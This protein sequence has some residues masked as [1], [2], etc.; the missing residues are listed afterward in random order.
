M[1]RGR[2]RKAESLKALE[3]TQREDRKN[4]NVSKSTILLPKPPENL[5]TWQRMAWVDLAALINPLRI[6][7]DADIIAFRQM[8]IA[9]GIVEQARKALDDAGSLTYEIP[10]TAGGTRLVPRPEVEVMAKYQRILDMKLAQFGMTPADRERVAAAPA[11]V[12]DD[13]LDEFAVNG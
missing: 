5:N 3:G 4:Q 6:T 7:T 8:A 13:P 11:E 12:A 10:M 2:P 1:P 9:L